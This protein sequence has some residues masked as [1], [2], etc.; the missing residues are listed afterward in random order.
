MIN[1]VKGQ[2]IGIEAGLKKVTVGLGWDPNPDKNNPFDLDASAF[3]LGA[4]EKLPR[5]E[6]FVFYNNQKSPDAAVESLGDDLNGENSDGGDDETITVDLDKVSPEVQSIVFTATIYE[7]DVRRQNF[8]QVRNAYIRIYDEV[9]GQEIARYDLDEDF[10]IESAVEFGRL[11]RHNGLWKFQAMGDGCK[12]G[13]EAL[14]NK[15]Q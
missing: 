8:G 12:G 6:F 15:Y 13:L 10:S 7:Y 4:N 14:V 9:S 2:R 11:Y 5:D 1:L 3:M